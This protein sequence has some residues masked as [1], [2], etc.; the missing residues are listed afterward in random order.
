MHKQGTISHGQKLNLGHLK[1]SEVRAGLMNMPLPRAP[2]TPNRRVARKEIAA[3]AIGVVAVARSCAHLRRIERA[4]A[5]S[6]GRLADCRP[7]ITAHS[8]TQRPGRL[9]PVTKS[10]PSESL[11]G[12]PID[13]CSSTFSSSSS[14][15]DCC[16]PR[17]THTAKGWI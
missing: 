14:H 3:L 10:Q 12:D 2:D 16:W 17:T 7:S 1:F 4:S 9:H 15:S 6:V 11:V 13:P 8:R 5:H